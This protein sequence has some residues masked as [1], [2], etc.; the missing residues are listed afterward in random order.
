MFGTNLDTKH[1]LSTK[2]WRG[3]LEPRG[4]HYRQHSKQQA[5]CHDKIHEIIEA[6]PPITVTVATR[7]IESLEDMA[8][9]GRT[10][11]LAKLDVCLDIMMGC[12]I[13]YITLIKH[14]IQ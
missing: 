12:A 8:F 13:T 9:I 14:F 4:C 1:L 3:Q 7:E 6:R 10:L 5:R 2:A 11:A